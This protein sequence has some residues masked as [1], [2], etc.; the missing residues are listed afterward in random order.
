M[1]GLRLLLSLGAVI[2]WRRD[3]II[4]PRI[5]LQNKFAM[6]WIGGSACR[7][8]IRTRMVSGDPEPRD[9]SIGGD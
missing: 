1:I 6:N 5:R 4:S 2:R 3:T 8:P 7:H 9:E